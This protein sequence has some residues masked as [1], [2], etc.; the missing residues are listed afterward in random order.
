MVL[1]DTVEGTTQNN[2]KLRYLDLFLGPCET[3]RLPN[4][5]SL[6]SLVRPRSGARPRSSHKRIN[7]VCRYDTSA[8][9]SAGVKCLLP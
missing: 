8:L 4:R 5:V 1:Q 9:I 7:V 2:P 3:D 6:V